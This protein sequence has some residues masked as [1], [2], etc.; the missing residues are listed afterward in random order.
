MKVL[1]IGFGDLARRLGARVAADG[2]VV[3]ALRRTPGTEPGVRLFTGDCRDGELLRAALEG[4]DAVVVTLTPDAFT[5]E[6][7]RETYVACARALA[8]ALGAMASVPRQLVWVSSTSVYGQGN[9]EWVDEDSPAEPRGF[10]GCCLR[11]AEAIVQAL[12]LSVTVVRFSGIYGP[13]RT[14]LIDQVRRGQ[15]APSEPVQW[16][17]RIHSDD[18]AGVLHHLLTLAAGG[19]ALESLYLGTDCEPVPLH[20]VHHWLAGRLGVPVSPV[21]GGVERGN[22]R[23]SNARLLASGYRFIYPGF[24]EGY[25]ALLAA[26]GS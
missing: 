26:Q 11:E 5:E 20:E 9:G 22:R 25:G 17:N 24:R 18:C 10:S 12:P 2:G 21:V 4:Q 6:A 23:C 19:A 7:Y 14:R 8:D 13:G 1:L 16:T 15:C 3:S